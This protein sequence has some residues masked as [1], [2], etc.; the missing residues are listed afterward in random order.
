LQVVFEQNRVAA[1][2]TPTDDYTLLSAH[3][4]RNFSLGHTQLEVFLR[5]SNLTDDE[6]RPHTSFVKHLAPLAGRAAV[7]GVRLAF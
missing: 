1:S 5:G 3:V 7:A 4:S 6:A 2:E